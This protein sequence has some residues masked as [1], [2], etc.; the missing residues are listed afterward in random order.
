MAD[1][2]LRARLAVTAVAV[3]VAVLAG[4][5]R[6]AVDDAG[7]EVRRPSLLLFVW[8]RGGSFRSGG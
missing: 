4:A 2:A 3:A 1:A 5:A 8:Q 7:V 6:A